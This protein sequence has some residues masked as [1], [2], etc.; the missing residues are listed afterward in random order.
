MQKVNCVE[1]QKQ[2]VTSAV[3]DNID[4][5]V[6]VTTDYYRY[7]CFYIVSYVYGL[8]QLNV[9]IWCG[10]KN[11]QQIMTFNVKTGFSEAF[12]SKYISI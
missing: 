10:G 9:I 5:L 4:W 12:T 11:L 3:S 1:K 7:L 6:M 8:V 2:A